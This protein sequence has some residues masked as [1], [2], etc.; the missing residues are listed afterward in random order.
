MADNQQQPLPKIYSDA[1]EATTNSKVSGHPTLKVGTIKHLKPPGPDSNYL[2]WSWVLDIHFCSTGVFYLLD[3]D[4]KQAK[5]RKSKVS[6]GQ[7]NL[8]V[9]LVIAKTIHPGNIRYV[10]QYN[11]NARKLWNTLKAAHQDHLSGGMMYWL[12]K[13]TISCMTGDDI[14]AHLDNMGKIYENLNSLVSPENPLTTEN[15]FSVSILTSLPQDWLACVSSMMNDK[16]VTPTCIID[17]LKQEDLRQKACAQDLLQPESA[18]KTAPSQSDTSRSGPGQYF[19]TF[20]KKNGHSLERC[21]E[22]ARI[23]A[24]HAPSTPKEL[25]GCRTNNCKRRDNNKGPAK[26]G[27]TTVVE[28]GGDGRDEE[29]DY[30]GSNNKSYSKSAK[31]GN[32]SVFEH[33]ET[34]LL[35]SHR[36]KDANIDSRCSIS[37]TPYQGDVLSACPD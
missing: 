5:L 33:P 3:P 31:A 1:A 25:S 21:N 23:L 36:K 6:F 30:S 2:E 16:Q 19:C 13:L 15:I 27:Q 20:C 12:Q 28:L 26:A 22:A 18:A 10:R 4:D 29:S 11:T 24:N 9:C 17:A 35:S 8:A 32:V 14:I 34:A 37:M 7:D